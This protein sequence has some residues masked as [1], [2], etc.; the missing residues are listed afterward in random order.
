MN[1]QQ[2]LAWRRARAGKATASNF[3]VIMDGG[4]RAW[5]TLAN[6]LLIEEREWAR[7]ST[8]NDVDAAP[9]RW[10]RH[11][12]PAA[13]A[14]YTIATGFQVV[15]PEFRTLEGRDDIGCSADGIIMDGPAGPHG[16]EIKC[17]YSA[18]QHHRYA[19]AGPGGAMA[20][21]QGSMWIWG[22]D[23]WDFASYDPREQHDLQLFIHQVRR[24]DRY[25]ARLSQRVNEF[26]DLLAARRHEFEERA[27]IVEHD[28]KLSRQEA[29]DLSL[30]VLS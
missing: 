1:D 14:R 11:H 10:G 2:Y 22:Y 6:K 26:A 21:V 19:V 24:D 23:R 8:P 12:E 18:A 3:R 15:V 30:E 7:G 5:S 4:P 20:Q 27:A 17:P 9:L 25:I 28:G 29:E 13:R 16:L